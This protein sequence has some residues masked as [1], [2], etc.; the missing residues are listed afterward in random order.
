VAEP[1]PEG[2]SLSTLELSLSVLEST[3]LKVDGDEFEVLAIRMIQA[4]QELK[5]EIKK[6]GG[7]A[8]GEGAE[9]A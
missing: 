6:R 8:Q 3:Q 4:K 2:V 1:R 5:A 7:G 9:S